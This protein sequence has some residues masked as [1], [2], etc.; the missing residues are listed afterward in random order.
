M[1]TEPCDVP[2]LIGPGRRRDHEADRL[3][4]MFDVPDSVGSA[5]LGPRR[6]PAR[7]E[8]PRRPA[9][10][11]CGSRPSRAIHPSQSLTWSFRWSGH[12]PCLPL[13]RL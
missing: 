12:F 5:A 4:A 6:P 2:E 8:D 1:T 9:S 11:D 13:V 3:L 7:T 10:D